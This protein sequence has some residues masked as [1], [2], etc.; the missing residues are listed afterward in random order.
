MAAGSLSTIRT[1]GWIPEDGNAVYD[2]RVK[3]SGKYRDPA[4][5]PF[6]VFG[7]KNIKIP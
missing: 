4:S 2:R 1:E 3:S 5:L 6:D 7:W